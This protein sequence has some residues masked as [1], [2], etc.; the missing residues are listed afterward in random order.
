MAKTQNLVVKIDHDMQEALR[1]K[2]QETGVPVSEVVRR[3]LEV[4]LETGELPKLPESRQK[5]G[6]VSGKR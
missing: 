3:A 5:G 1:R 4:W 6:G 2:S